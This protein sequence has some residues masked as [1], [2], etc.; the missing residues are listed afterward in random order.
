[1]LLWT[2][3]RKLLDTKSSV[4]TSQD[5]IQNG[6]KKLNARNAR[7][8]KQT[9]ICP[10]DACCNEEEPGRFTYRIFSITWKKMKNGGGKKI[11]FIL[12]DVIYW[13]PEILPYVQTARG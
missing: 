6:G 9:I 3:Q 2:F 13:F 4:I 12:C 11:I 10:F 1:M 7:K 5:I 8:E